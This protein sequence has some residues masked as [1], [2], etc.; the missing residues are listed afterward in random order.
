MKRQ[1]NP[2]CVTS[3]ATTV[4]PEVTARAIVSVPLTLSVYLCISAVCIALVVF[5]A[6]TASA[7]AYFCGRHTT[8]GILHTVLL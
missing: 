2:H 5:G 6:S 7:A 1:K 3:D 8:V 4:S